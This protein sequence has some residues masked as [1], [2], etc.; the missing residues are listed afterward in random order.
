MILVVSF[1]NDNV[2]YAFFQ[3]QFQI[4]STEITEPTSKRPK[5]EFS[6]AVSGQLGKD[7]IIVFNIIVRGITLVL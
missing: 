4:K 2:I 3:L 1:I 7:C 6:E 5:T